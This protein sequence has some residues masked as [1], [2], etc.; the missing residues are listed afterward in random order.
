[1][2]D[3]LREVLKDQTKFKELAQ[4]SFNELQNSGYI[5]PEDVE[6]A[7]Q[8]FAMRINMAPPGVSE[9][10]EILE[11]LEIEKGKSLSFE[12]YSKVVKHLVQQ[13]KEEE[14][15]IDSTESR[16][17]NETTNF[18]N[19]LEETGITYAFKVI[20]AEIITKKIEPGEVFSYSAM[21]MRQIKKEIQ[22]LLPN[23][24]H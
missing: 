14:I 12:D 11:Q 6:K 5:S 23:N 20:F 15:P 4:T 17:N 21:R 8:N 18:E 9:V 22:H 13:F 1:M 19:Y 7:T 2:S 16:V 10:H 24:K 3:E